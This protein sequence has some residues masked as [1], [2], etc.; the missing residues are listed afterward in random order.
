MPNNRRLIPHD[1][2]A[3]FCYSPSTF[4]DSLVS[5]RASVAA[6]MPSARAPYRRP[7]GSFNSKGRGTAFHG[8]AVPLAYGR[9]RGLRVTR[10][11]T[12]PI[13]AVVPLRRVKEPGVLKGEFPNRNPQSS[14]QSSSQSSSQSWVWGEPFSILFSYETLEPMLLAVMENTFH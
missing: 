9:I 7:R 14:R 3:T 11:Q 6:Y 10:Y 4:A 8:R 2:A 5:G 12:G 13:T 1:P